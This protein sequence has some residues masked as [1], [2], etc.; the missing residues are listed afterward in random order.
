VPDPIP[1]SFA[2]AE[3]AWFWT[4]SVV[5][6]RQAPASARPELRSGAA[7]ARAAEVLRCLDTL[8]RRRRIDLLD[9]RILKHWGE[10]GRA[11]DPS[12]SSER[13]DEPIWREAIGRLT[14]PLRVRGIVADP[15]GS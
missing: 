11:P 7:A 14:W 2:T 1:P 3:Q 6:A 4:M 9:A 10:R 13:C 8:Y 5:Q 15:P 12:R